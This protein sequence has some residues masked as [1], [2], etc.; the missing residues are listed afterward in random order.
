[1]KG[2]LGLRRIHGHLLL[3]VLGLVLARPGLVTNLAG[4]GLVAM[5]LVVR[6]WAAGVLQKGGGLCTDGPYQYVRHPLYVGSLVAA[7]GF[8]VMMSVVWAWAVVLPLFIVLYA[9]QVSLEER[10]L[11]AEYGERHREYAAEV[12]KVVPRLRSGGVGG[13][14]RWSFSQALVNREQYHVFV[15]VGLVALFYAKWYWGW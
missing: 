14:R 5:G 9:V 10:L 12:P 15:T 1:M 13:G 6:V 4:G 3:A 11:R 7:L 2:A 8:C